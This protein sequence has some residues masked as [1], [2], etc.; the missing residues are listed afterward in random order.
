MSLLEIGCKESRVH[1][2]GDARYAGIHSSDLS[3]VGVF[4]SII[5]GV[6]VCVCEREREYN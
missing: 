4:S 5:K 1:C 2:S 6:Y 3:V